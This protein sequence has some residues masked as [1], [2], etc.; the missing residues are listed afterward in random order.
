MSCLQLCFELDYIE[1]NPCNCSN[2]SLGNV[3]TD[4]FLKFENNP[5]GCT[6]KNK[7]DFFE[8][9]VLEKCLKYCP[10][11]CDSERYFY[12]I[13]S[14]NTISKLINSSSLGNDNFTTF[15]IFY[16]NLNVQFITQKPKIQLFDLIS[17][18][19]GI[20]G[21]FIGFGF[22]SLFEFGELLLEIILILLE[23]FKIDQRP[24]I[25]Y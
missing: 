25:R 11:Q 20:F 6:I 19:G 22:V 7:Q 5:M 4:C 2:T 21:L 16:N 14:S 1:K 10:L 12:T 24:S 8:K 13:S 15:W 18:I 3:W 23:K 9:S 17:N